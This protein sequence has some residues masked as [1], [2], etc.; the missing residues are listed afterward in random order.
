MILHPAGGTSEHIV[1]KSAITI[2]SHSIGILSVPVVGFGFYG[3]A[4]KLR[5]D[6]QLS[7]LGLAFAGFALVSILMAGVLNGLVLPLYT[8]KNIDQITQ[9]SELVR[10]LI[11]YNL[12]FNATLDY[13]FIGGYSIAMLIWS[14]LIL[15]TAI[16]PRWLGYMGLALVGITL[17]GTIARLNFISVTGFTIYIFG[18]VSW[19][20]I[21][22][23][24]LT[25][26]SSKK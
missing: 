13:V 15:Q 9:N 2:I 5:V 17:T 8:S 10:Q 6:N 19:I 26:G 20:V 4:K 23:F 22:G 16:L 7:Y 14:A 21:A 1:A 18:I 3:L 24:Q 11:K 12:T 25:R